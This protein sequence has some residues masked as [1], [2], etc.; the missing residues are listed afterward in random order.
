[1]AAVAGQVEAR[2]PILKLLDEV[3]VRETELDWLATYEADNGRYKVRGTENSDVSAV[4]ILN[5]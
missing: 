1:M 3:S 2:A 4:Y 5:A